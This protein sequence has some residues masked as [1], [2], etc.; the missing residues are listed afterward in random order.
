M[1]WTV[2]FTSK[3]TK[4]VTKLPKKERDLLALLVRDIQLNG[5]VQASWKNYSKL[6]KDTYHCH[7]SYKW[8]ACWRMED[9]KLKV[10]EVYYA[11]SRENA[12]Y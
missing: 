10:I 2:L 9:N 11:G 3:A 5:P 4:Q 7:L 8:V 6:E 1:S 12:P